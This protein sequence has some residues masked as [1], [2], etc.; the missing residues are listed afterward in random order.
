MGQTHSREAELAESRRQTTQY[1]WRIRYALGLRAAEARVHE[2][3]PGSR[4]NDPNV[5]SAPHAR[6]ENDTQTSN[7]YAH[8]LTESRGNTGSPKR[9]QKHRRGKFK[10]DHA[11]SSGRQPAQTDDSHAADGPEGRAKKLQRKKL[12]LRHATPESTKEC[13][14]CT[15]TRP[16]FQFPERP[17]TEDCQHS[18]DTCTH[19]LQT[20]IESEFKSKMWNEVNCPTCR[21]R[22]QFNDVKDFAP[23]NVFV[24]Y[25]KLHTKAI[26]DKIPNWRWCVARG[27]KSGQIHDDTDSRFRYKKCKRSHCAVHLVRWH[28]KET[29][30]EYEYR[31]NTGIRQQEELASY[32]LITRTTK[33]CPGCTRSIEQSYR[34]DHMTCSECRTEFCWVC[35]A[36]YA[37]TPNTQTPTVGIEHSTD[38]IHYMPPRGGLENLYQLYQLR[39]ENPHRQDPRGE[40]V[41]R[42]RDR[43]LGQAVRRDLDNMYQP[44]STDSPYRRITR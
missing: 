25:S 1:K 14:V 5:G 37:R 16:L 21:A 40:A 43:L 33:V 28:T 6:T 9:Q 32:S 12:E 44:R 17:P 22:L 26:Y 11:K 29:C 35:L 34:C 31:T 20:W 24:R 8:T 27:C 13:N 7:D 38:C 19:C 10:E 4:T 41:G 23:R 39:I 36:S 18:I 2:R 15:E 42:D 3:C 30:R